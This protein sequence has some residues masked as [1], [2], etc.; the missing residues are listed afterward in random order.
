MIVMPCAVTGK[1]LRSNIKTVAMCGRRGCRSLSNGPTN[2]DQ[3]HAT[4]RAPVFFSLNVLFYLTLGDAFRCSV[5][6]CS[7]STSPAM[8]ARVRAASRT[9]MLRIRKLTLSCAFAAGPE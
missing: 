3:A 8:F 1:E 4:R 6:D 7:S 5:P 9:E 2:E